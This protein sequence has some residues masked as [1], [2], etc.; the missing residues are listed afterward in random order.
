MPSCCS[1]PQKFVYNFSSVITDTNG[2]SL[3]TELIA[4]IIEVSKAEFQHLVA[5]LRKLSDT[6][7]LFDLGNQLKAWGDGTKKSGYALISLIS[8]TA[9]RILGILKT[10]HQLKIVDLTIYLSSVGQMPVVGTL[11][12]LPTQVFGIIGL[13]FGT[14]DQFKKLSA[15]IAHKKEC[16]NIQ[17][18]WEIANDYLVQKM[19]NEP[20]AKFNAAEFNEHRLPLHVR[21][22]PYTIARE[23]NP[24]DL[25]WRIQLEDE[26]KAFCSK[27]DEQTAAVYIT[28]YERVKEDIDLMPEHEY[29]DR[30]F[31][32]TDTIRMWEVYAENAA[33]EVK[34]ACLTIVSNVARAV[35]FGVA[36]YAGSSALLVY[37]LV[38]AS[39]G[40]I[41]I[42]YIKAHSL[43]VPLPDQQPW[44]LRT[45]NP[46][47]REQSDATVH[48]STP[49]ADS[50]SGTTPD[51]AVPSN[52]LTDSEKNFATFNSAAS[53]VAS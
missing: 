21:K 47:V 3:T 23:A 52:S 7:I 12:G 42:F 46:D 25:N 35:F 31:L 48:A 9:F 38:A 16:Q 44:G 22:S 26:Q 50:L 32:Q 41:K 5:P 13:T 14:L 20:D 27:Y 40:M 34:I 39:T 18:L 10:A 53:P 43:Q 51:G 24:K 28:D 8:M 36:I 6:M 2:V 19:R 11:L 37:G 4:A 29:A 33:A 1:I 15:S 49:T 17:K 45:A 30:N